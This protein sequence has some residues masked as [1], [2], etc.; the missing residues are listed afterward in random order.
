VDLPKTLFFFIDYIVMQGTG[1]L[2]SFIAPM[3]PCLYEKN[4]P[5][6]TFPFFPPWTLFFNAGHHG[7]I[8]IRVQV[9]VKYRI[10]LAAP[11]R[12][13]HRGFALVLKE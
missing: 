3:L 9:I 2:R 12:F 10:F 11:V 7:R 13:H 5:A 1:A 6:S 4:A 8:K